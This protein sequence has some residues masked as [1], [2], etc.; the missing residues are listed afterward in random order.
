MTTPERHRRLQALAALAAR[1]DEAMRATYA[2]R[3]DAA[4]DAERLDLDAVVVRLESAIELVLGQVD[5]APAPA[6]QDLPGEHETDPH[7]PGDL[8]WRGGRP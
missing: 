8:E 1:L 3:A 5:P 6:R 2:A 4:D 7:D